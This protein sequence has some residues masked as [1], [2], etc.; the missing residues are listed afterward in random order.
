MENLLRQW[1]AKRLRQ[2]ITIGDGRLGTSDIQQDIKCLGCDKFIAISERKKWCSQKCYAKNIRLRRRK[3]L[4]KKPCAN[5]GELF[6]PSSIKN[7]LCSTP[8]RDS[9][10]RFWNE[11]R[12]ERARKFREKFGREKINCGYCGKTFEKTT[13]N[14]KYCSNKC[15][16]AN[17]YKI[18]T[19]EIKTFT[20]T[21]RDV[22][23]A[24]IKRS[25]FS[26]E[27]RAFKKAGKKIVSFPTISE[28]QKDLIIKGCDSD[29]LYE[30][31][32]Q[33]YEMNRFITNEER[34]K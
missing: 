24:D 25:Q 15:R 11:Q 23:D 22:T 28:K 29:S 13:P 2:T 7:T 34:T 19:L 18:K 30:D 27:I 16:I 6:R 17:N 1:I 20:A 9:N 12:N 31:L 5:C 3:K 26:E 4:D 33:F 21:L 32:D 8:C 10:R 14:R